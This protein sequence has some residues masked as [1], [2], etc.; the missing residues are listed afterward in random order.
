MRRTVLAGVAALLVLGLATTLG[1]NVGGLRDRLLGQAG[2]TPIDSLAVLPLTNQSGDPEQEYFIDGITEALIT[3][4]AKISALKVISRNSSMRYR[5]TDKSIPEIAEELGVDAVIEGSVLRSGDSVRV[6]AQL[7]EARTDQY[8]WADNFDRELRDIL[9]LYSDVARAIAQEIEIA[10]TPEEETR[11]ARTRPVDPEA[12]ELYVQGRYQFNLWPDGLM[13]ATELFQQAVEKDPNFTQAYAALAYS[14]IVLGNFH[15]RPPNEVFPKAKAAAL[16]AQEM[17]DTL[18]ETQRALFSVKFSYER[19]WQG[20]DKAIARCLEIN[21]GD[22]E[23]HGW[24]AERLSMIGRH[25]EAIAEIKKAWELDPHMWRRR[26]DVGMILYFARQYDQAIQH[27]QEMIEAHPNY[28]MSHHYLSLVFLQKGMFAEAIE[29]AEKGLELSNRPGRTGWLAHAYAVAG[30][31]DEAR[32]ILQ[33]LEREQVLNG[34]IAAIHTALGDTD[35]AFAWL[36]K[37]YDA[38]DSWLFQLQ[39]PVWDP[40]R[41]DPRFKDLMRR[42]NLPVQ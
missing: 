24:Y 12:Y 7:I 38:Y 37:A 16:K 20:V 18:F 32:K 40:L 41:D 35:Q 29:E 21:P 27:L 5:D 42:L 33:E 25:D 13:K 15:F 2:P 22:S 30:R 14:Y 8:L 1:L 10:V 11:L 19:D 17:D 34:W 39:D 28:A 23:V 4:L 31:R 26:F 6:T 9:A 3:D 36:D